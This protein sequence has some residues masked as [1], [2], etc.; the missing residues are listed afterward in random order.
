MPTSTTFFLYQK[1]KE[2]KEKKLIFGRDLVTYF[3][4]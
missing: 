3:L 1:P 2:K 4:K